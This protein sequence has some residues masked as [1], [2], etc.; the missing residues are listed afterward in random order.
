MPSRPDFT[1]GE[2]LL[3][4]QKLSCG[5]AKQLRIRSYV[6]RCYEFGLQDKINLKK[7]NKMSRHEIT[8][9]RNQLKKE[10]H[11]DLLQY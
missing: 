6:N 8:F 11:I 9:A 10:D 5:E 1:N 7:L 3:E 2:M 4:I